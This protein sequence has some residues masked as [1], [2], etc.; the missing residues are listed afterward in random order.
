MVGLGE[1][2]MVYPRQLS[3]GELRRVAIAR[4]LMNNPEILLADEPTADL[5]V[6]TELNIIT[7]LKQI[8]ESGVTVMMITHNLD[9]VRYATRALKVEG[10]R[11][12]PV[13][14]EDYSNLRESARL[15]DNADAQVR[16]TEPPIKQARVTE[17]KV[18]TAYTVP[19]RRLGIHP[20]TFSLALT[21]AVMGMAALI[22][23]LWGK[24]ELAQ[25]PITT[26]V[27]Q[28]L[29]SQTF[30]GVSALAS[31]PTSLRQYGYLAA[32]FDTM[33]T[34]EIT[35]RVQDFPVLFGITSVPLSWI[36]TSFSGQFT[37]ASTGNED[38]IIG[39]LS[40]D[41]TRL[42]SLV[43]S[44]RIAQS[45]AAKKPVFYISL[46]DLALVTMKH[47]A[48]TGRGTLEIA[49]ADLQENIVKMEYAD[50]LPNNPNTAISSAE[51]TMGGTKGKLW[52][53]KITFSKEPLEAS[54][55]HG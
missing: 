36:G 8:H 20:V 52:S 12:V 31:G 55:P 42:I 22:F 47:D 30:S 13:S 1:R 18:Q 53:F 44:R 40:E 41:S 2:R 24:P 16:A 27:A 29:S 28:N 10:G 54:S 32:N 37:D 38:T 23:S 14:L 11:L 21:A 46:K 49:A 4:A 9:L 6:N 3:A 50:A 25:P 15:A 45:G 7:L 33:M 34:F 43:Y 48:A 19:R 51:R 5:D 26:P 17:E 39:V 35:G